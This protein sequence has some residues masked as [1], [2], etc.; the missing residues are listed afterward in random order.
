[1]ELLN[2]NDLQNDRTNDLNYYNLQP[3]N[4]AKIVNLVI[5]GL[6]RDSVQLMELSQKIKLMAGVE[7][8]AVVMG[9]SSNKAALKSLGLLSRE[10]EEAAANDI[11]IAVKGEGDVEAVLREAYRMVVESKLKIS[12]RYHSI[13]EAIRKNPE[14]KYASISIPGQYV[15]G[16][17]YE[18]L[19]HG[20]NLFIFSDH[21]PVDIEVELKKRAVE[22]GLMV[23]GPEAGTSIINGVGFG[24]ANRVRKGPVGVV[25]SAGSGIQEFIT[26]LDN[27]D[28]G[29][30]H[31]IGVG[32][33]DLTT[34]VG[35]LM[36]AEALRRLDNDSATKIIA[37]IAK[38]SDMEVAHKVLEEVSPTKPVITCLLGYNG[39]ELCGYKHEQTIHG[40]ALRICSMLEPTKYQTVLNILQE[41]VEKLKQAVE[42]S[43]HS[44]GFYCGGTLATETAYIWKQAGIRVYSN[45]GVDWVEKLPNPYESIASTVVDYGT[46]EFTEGRPH[47]IIDPSLRNR[48]V[49]AELVDGTVSNVLMDLIIGYG[50]P[51]NVI[52]KTLEDIGADRIRRTRAKLV[53]RLV[54]CSSDRQWSEIYKIQKYPI[55]IPSSNAM[56]AAFSA[57]L[58]LGEP[59]IL[60]NLFKELIAH[61]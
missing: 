25:A 26:L 13:E 41:E 1:M 4:V 10:G 24:F 39:Q 58:G 45:L 35:G 31:A 40:L 52:S 15:S 30:S 11:I 57:A 53:V 19:E 5:K 47:P 33:R 3:H 38:Q 48:R 49:S 6:Y 61:G 46:E 21:V 55:I 60:E 16:V 7:D 34:R 36:T 12:E 59:E 32:G 27:M 17:A 20:I 22:K 42:N 37:L 44:R 2:L 56:A 54:G 18:L 51:E 23:M 29:V 28:V 43:G 50:A 9:T 14:I 8:G